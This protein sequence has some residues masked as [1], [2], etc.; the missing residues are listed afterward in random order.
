MASQEEMQDSERAKLALDLAFADLANNVPPEAILGELAKVEPLCA[1]GSADRAR[2]LHARGLVMNRMGA[3]GEALGDLHESIGLYSKL[4]DRSTVARVWRAIALVH[5]WRGNGREAAFALFRV[6][7]EGGN[8]A[9]N[10]AL[11]LIDAGKLELEIGRLRD[12][13]VLLSRGL[14]M[15]TD[16]IPPGERRNALISLVKVLVDLGE[17]DKARTVLA[18]I[19]LEA[20]TARMRHLCAIEEA[21]IAIRD[22]KLTD[23]RHLLATAGDLAPTE[24]GAFDRIELQQAEA[25]FALADKNPSAAVEL[26]RDVIAR[27]ASDDLAGREVVARLFEAKALDRLGRAEDADRTLA[28]ALRRA[29]GRGLSGYADEIRAE[30]AL[31][32]RPHDALPPALE[33]AASE[34]GQAGR[35]VRRRPL[36]AG[37]FGS[38]SRAYDLELGKEVALKRLQLASIY[39][40]E[41]RARRLDAAR[42]EVAAASRI[43]HPGVGQV[44]GLLIEPD[45]EVLLIR[46]LVEGPTLREAMAGNLGVAEKLG[47]AAHLAHCL[48]AIHTAGVVHRDLKPENVV[49]RLGLMPVIIDFGVS[50]ISGQRS[51][52]EGANTKNYAAPEQL[53][54]G[55]VDPRSDL[56]ALGTICYELFLGK[57]PERAEGGI[58]GLLNAEDRARHIGEELIS[59][60]APK[61]AGRVVAQLLA[62][63]R[64]NRPSNARDVALALEG[65]G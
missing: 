13:D 61:A 28:A 15:G 35:F 7:A 29:I 55:R 63:A 48:A 22:R 5:S 37:G 40:P 52:H 24:A 27:Y 2:L 53:R 18:S 60:G 50:T 59:A 3:P 32:G 56:Y 23:A 51:H 41:R 9:S 39:D 12:A 17:F 44:Y 30:L 8:Q 57:L 20:A 6:I 58:S 14:E 47:I 19:D 21:R 45:D 49:L 25:E 16:L 34:I 42:M 10:I 33:T 65:Q 38:V 1:P 11:A 54:G 62:H 36:G 26:M 43:H 46:E 4:G 31:R 64:R